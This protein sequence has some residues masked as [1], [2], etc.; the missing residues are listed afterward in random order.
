MGKDEEWIYGRW[1][2]GRDRGL[3]TASYE[4]YPNSYGF[5]RKSGMKPHVA[6]EVWCRALLDVHRALGGAGGDRNL[7]DER[8]WQLV[9]D[10]LRFLHPGPKG[11]HFLHARDALFSAFAAAVQAGMLPGDPAL[12]QGVEEAFRVRGMGPGAASADAEFGS[13]REAF[14]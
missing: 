8:G 14:S 6:G 1:L 3:R 12:R 4:G 10:S 9:L 11:P 7:G 2:S 5:L 13:A